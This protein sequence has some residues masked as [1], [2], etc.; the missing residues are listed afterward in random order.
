MH[1]CAQNAVEANRDRRL[2]LEGHSRYE[3]GTA[4]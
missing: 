2:A 1:Y 4:A 3:A